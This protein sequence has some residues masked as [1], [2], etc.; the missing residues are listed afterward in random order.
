MKRRV[1]NMVGII[2]TALLLGSAA[3]S[4]N[5]APATQVTFEGDTITVSS[6]L[7]LV[8]RADDLNT[9]APLFESAVNELFNEEQSLYKCYSLNFDISVD[10]MTNIPLNQD[11]HVVS[12][13][14]VTSDDATWEAFDQYG[15]YDVHPWHLYDATHPL[16]PD[17]STQCGTYHG[18]EYDIECAQLSQ[19][20]Y[21]YGLTDTAPIGYVSSLESVGFNGSGESKTA[22]VTNASDTQ[23]LAHELGHILGF[24]HEEGA[25]NLMNPTA[26]HNHTDVTHDNLHDTLSRM[27]LE[28]RWDMEINGIDVS[29][30][31]ELTCPN[32]QC[33]ID[34]YVKGHTG[35][36]IESF[37]SFV[38]GTGETVIDDITADGCGCSASVLN[39]GDLELTGTIENNNE[40][41]LFAEAMGL[42]S[43]GAAYTMNLTTSYGMPPQ[44][45]F[46]APEPTQIMYYSMSEGGFDHFQVDLGNPQDN[47]QILTPVT[48][49]YHESNTYT[50]AIISS[51][52]SSDELIITQV[53]PFQRPYDDTFPNFGE[54]LEETYGILI[55]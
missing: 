51:S 29:T 16:E 39:N 44:E 54:F 25:Q 55:Q 50:C 11:A 48:V 7:G 32:P 23:V 4:Q 22:V 10:E 27:N 33:Q 38:A 37:G 14:D 52:L 47:R 2:L 41:S 15:L 6:A 9:M 42:G 34:R 12:I 53:E 5:Q 31:P 13:I 19:W 18:L 49:E 28:C 20:F 3:H 8:G 1:M 45:N 17:R 40:D 46:C 36:Q 26:G 35:W 21:D 43:L 30:T 24:T